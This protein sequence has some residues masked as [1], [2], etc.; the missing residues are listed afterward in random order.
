MTQSPVVNHSQTIAADR[1]RRL[2]KAGHPRLK[3]HTHSSLQ[4]DT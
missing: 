3:P 1:S 4:K 2:S